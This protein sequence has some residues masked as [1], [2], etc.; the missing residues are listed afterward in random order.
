MDPLALLSLHDHHQ[1][2]ELRERA[3]RRES[4]AE[5]VRLVHLK[6]GAGMVIHST[7]TT[8]NADRVISEQIAYFEEL[9]QDFEWKTY[10]HDRPLDLKERLAARGFEAEEPESLLTLDLEDAP[11][12][13]L[14]PL[15][16]EVRRIHEPSALEEIRRIQEQVWGE[17]DSAFIADLK[18]ELIH[19]P[20]HVSVYIAYA[21]GIPV[22]HARITFHDASPFAGLWGGSTLEEYR[23]LGFYTSLLAARVQEARAR[24]VRFL[25]IDASPMSRSIVEKRG[26]RFLTMTQPFHWHVNRSGGHK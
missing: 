3:F 23:G 24:G 20:E 13:L 10:D 4:T 21:G 12:E 1:R 25:T 9:G 5:V 14:K 2:S 6:Q 19:D 7:L 11:A 17:S 15:S 26:F 16:Q 8:E 22:A 18:D